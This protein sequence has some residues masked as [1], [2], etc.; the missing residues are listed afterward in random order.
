MPT[1]VFFDITLGGMFLAMKCR[2]IPCAEHSITCRKGITTDTN[3][4]TGEPLGRITFELFANI[5]PKTAENF[6][7]FCTG[8]TR[9]SLGRPQGYKGS[10]FHRIVLFL[11]PFMMPVLTHHR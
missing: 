11:L 3:D 2:N 8:E 5:T 1:S 7:V 4:N 10:K 6:R 9:N